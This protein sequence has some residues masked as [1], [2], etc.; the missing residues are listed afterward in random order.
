MP[1]LDDVAGYTYNAD[2]YCPAHVMSVLPTH[3]GGAFDGWADASGTLDSEA[4]LS[5]LAAAFDI[6][7][8]DPYS[9]DSDDF[10][11]VIF[12]SDVTEDDVCGVCYERLDGHDGSPCCIAYVTSGGSDHVPG[13]HG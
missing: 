5:E 10:P 12:A 7:Y 11:K 4:F 8:A 13:C 9:Y 3:E 1:K 2:N 6:D